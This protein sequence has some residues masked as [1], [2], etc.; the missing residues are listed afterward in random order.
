M[1]TLAV[2]SIDGCFICY[3][4]A[5]LGYPLC[6]TGWTGRPVRGGSE[7]HLTDLILCGGLFA[8]LLFADLSV[9]DNV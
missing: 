6:A 7:V 1:Y 8:D 9:E 4:I 2:W 3:I 5:R